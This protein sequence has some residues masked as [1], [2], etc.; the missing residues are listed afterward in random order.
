MIDYNSLESVLEAIFEICHEK[1]QH[2]LSTWQD[3][4]LATEWK[5]AAIRMGRAARSLHDGMMNKTPG[6]NC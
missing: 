1:E 3:K 5:K 6:I 4:P 2:I